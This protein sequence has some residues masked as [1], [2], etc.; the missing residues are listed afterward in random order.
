MKTTIIESELEVRRAEKKLWRAEEKKAN[1][2]R[3]KQYREIVKKK[4]EQLYKSAL[5]PVIDDIRALSPEELDNRSLEIASEWEI[6]PHFANTSSGYL[7][8][9]SGVCSNSQHSDHKE[10]AKKNLAFIE[11]FAGQ[12]FASLEEAQAF[13]AADAKKRMYS[14]R[15]G[16]RSPLSEDEKR[17]IES[18]MKFSGEFD[19]IVERMEAEQHLGTEDETS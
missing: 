12:R 7:P 16:D 13:M 8:S 9:Y 19:R 17:S 3:Q 18:E 14:R 15:S 5:K 6:D 10:L 4:R 2:E 1:L 11:K